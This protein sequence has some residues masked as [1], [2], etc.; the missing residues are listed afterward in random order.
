[1][2]ISPKSSVFNASSENPLR[3]CS[4][5]LPR[6]IVINRIKFSVLIFHGQFAGRNCKIGK[7]LVVEKVIP[8]QSCYR[9]APLESFMVALG[10]IKD[11]QLTAW[12]AG[13]AELLVACTAILIIVIT[14]V[15]AKIKPVI[16]GK[17]VTYLGVDVKIPIVSLTCL[18]F[19][20]FQLPG[21]G[22]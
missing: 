20:R 14:P 17:S 6:A 7:H 8:A 4:K 15:Q 18:S 2:Q 12:Q 19:L 1:M 21:V 5:N 13:N 3:S 11:R 16:G 22:H 10:N 9:I